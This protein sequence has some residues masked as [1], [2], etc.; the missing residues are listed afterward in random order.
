MS[1]EFSPGAVIAVA[2]IVFGF[3]VTVIMFR[4]QRELEMRKKG[5]PSWIACSDHL[6]FASI[7]VSVFCVFLPTFLLP[8]F[9]CTVAIARAGCVAAIILEAGY[10]PSILAHYRLGFGKNRIGGR[11]NPEPTERLFI[12]I[13]AILAIGCF[14]FVVRSNL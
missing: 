5:E 10:I 3:G 1:T 6:I 2:A 8:K 11:T 4:I 13:A 7:F 12:W 14:V 9:N